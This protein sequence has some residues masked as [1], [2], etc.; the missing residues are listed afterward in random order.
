MDAQVWVK[1]V[2]QSRVRGQRAKSLP[3]SATPL[4]LPQGP[5]LLHCRVSQRVRLSPWTH[6]GDLRKWTWP[7]PAAEKQQSSACAHTHTRT[8]TLGP[9]P[10]PPSLLLSQGVRVGLPESL[11]H[12]CWVNRPHGQMTSRG[13]F[14]SSVAGQREF[15]LE[16]T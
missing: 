12:L 5:H 11:P 15:S 4:P 8:H 2:V 16:S 6:P 9:S 1:F 13:T 3:D 10:C 14:S 7:S